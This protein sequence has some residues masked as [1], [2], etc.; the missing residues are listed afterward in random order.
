MGR[1]GVPRETLP[2]EHRVALTPEAAAKLIGKGIQCAVEAGAGEVAGFPDSQYRDRGIA[3]TASRTEVFDNADVILQ[4]RTY[5]ANPHG[6]DDLALLRNDQA[7]IGFTEPLEAH[8]QLEALAATGASVFA[9]ELMPRITRA[10]SMDAL[11]SMATIAGYK[12]V[13]LAAEQLPR[14]FPLMMTAAGTLAP[15]RVLIIGAGV[16]GLQAIATA[17]RLGAVVMAYDVRPVVKEQVESLGA[18]F[19]DLGLDTA[20]SEDAGHGGRHR[21]RDVAGVRRARG[22]VECDRLARGLAAHA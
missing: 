22:R 20:D 16:A 17:K 10:Q 3:V 6:S 19:V 13:L 2:G 1:I 4:V 15:A 9:M 11:S 14:L 8:E 18:R 5:G 12:A 21:R 7:L